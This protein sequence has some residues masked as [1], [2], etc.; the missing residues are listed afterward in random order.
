MNSFKEEMQFLSPDQI[1]KLKC[2]LQ[3]YSEELF[4]EQM[5][6]LDRDETRLFED[7]IPVQPLKGGNSKPLSRPFGCVILAGGQGSRLGYDLPKGCF[8][9]HLGHSLFSILAKKL[10]SDFGY[11]AIMTSEDNDKATR[12]FFE[13]HHYFD[14][15][16]SHIDFFKQPVIPVMASNKK[17]VLN[18][19]KELFLSPAG[20]GAFFQAFFKSLV[21]QKWKDLGI[22]VINVCPIDNFLAEPQDFELM[23]LI[24]EG[25]DLVVRGIEKR[26]EEKIGTLLQHNGQLMVVEYGQLNSLPP[27][28]GYSGLFAISIDF[29]VLAAEKQLNW[30]L[31]KKKGKIFSLGKE[32]EIEI[33]KF[34][35]FI[36]DPFV[37][38]KKFGVLN[39]C[40]K[41][42]FCPLKDKLGPYGIESVKAVYRYKEQL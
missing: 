24:Q 26:Q 31:A 33:I 30:N 13:H 29:L 23:N 22:E 41:K 34:E 17:W 28:L 14:L 39:T 37:E 4:Q 11:L 5:N 25:Y 2:Q 21:F 40:R 35:K 10:N 20:N 12:M 19:K 8:E 3:I 27:S 7:Y 6:A 38:A 36:F 18:S 32:E 15:N 16:P 9:L 42:Y 1:A